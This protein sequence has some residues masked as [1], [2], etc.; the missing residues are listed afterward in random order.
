MPNFTIVNGRPLWPSGLGESKLHVADGMIAETAAKNSEIID[1]DGAYILPGIVDIHGDGF[2]RV[3]MP[4]PGVF[5]PL[6]LALMETDRRLISN[7]VTTA[8]HSLSLS[9]E[10]G[11]RS[12]ERM[13][14]FVEALKAARR[15]LASDTRLHLRWETFALEE[16]DDAI[17]MLEGEESAIF[18]F[19]D[20]TTAMMEK[21]MS[22]RKLNQ[23]A[24]RSGITPAA[25]LER[26]S[27]IW[28]RKAHVP[29][30]IASM[31]G[32]AKQE[33][34]IL[35]AHDERSV[36][37]RRWF[38]SLGAVG[39]EFPT[40]TETASEARA[41][42]EHVVLGAPN[43]L[44][45][46]SHTGAMDATEAVRA[47]LCSVLASDY[48]YPAQLHAAFSL[49]T[50]GVCDLASAWRLVSSNPAS[51]AGLTDR[52]DLAAG[53]RADIILVDWNGDGLPAI[54]TVYSNGLLARFTGH[55]APSPIARAADL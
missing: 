13:R 39:C 6:D 15:R 28:E 47:G 25:Y 48:F 18:S 38:R 41:H 11:L 12:L 40:T 2:E 52:G 53:K 7:G 49:V 31:A 27:A 42:D 30:A 54:K 5:F 19:N 36:E 29:D 1:A 21:R 24:E 32:R 17:K 20:H 45:G 46:G 34:A 51:L 4:R 22:E 35:L 26:L 33:G 8:F 50:K 37:E 10:P 3:I 23:M 9:W 14:S 16:A 44:R 55:P 43:V